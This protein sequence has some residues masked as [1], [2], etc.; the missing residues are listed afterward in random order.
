MKPVRDAGPIVAIIQLF[1]IL[2]PVEN[3][4][5]RVIED[6]NTT[7]NAFYILDHSA[8]EEKTKILYIIFLYLKDICAMFI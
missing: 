7:N 6:S 4:L 1:P 3:R 8:D 2:N 5:G